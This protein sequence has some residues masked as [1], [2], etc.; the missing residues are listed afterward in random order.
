MMTSDRVIKIVIDTSVVVA[1]LFNSRSVEILDQWN[2]GNLLFCYSGPILE[3]YKSVLKKIPPIRSKAQEFLGRL[4]SN[5]NSVLVQDPPW[6]GDI[7][8]EDQN[9]IKFI[10]CAVGAT[11]DYLVSL[12]D[13]LLSVEEHEDVQIIRPSD[14]LQRISKTP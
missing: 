3:E 2:R 4:E 12:D 8:I 14:F 10:A 13:H 5:Q 6:I 7:E 9:D 1:A 11:A